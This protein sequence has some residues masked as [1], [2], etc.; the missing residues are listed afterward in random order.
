MLV[1]GYVNE[2]FYCVCFYGL[3]L[4]LLNASNGMLDIIFLCEK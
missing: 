3:S 1:D 2:Y 4:T